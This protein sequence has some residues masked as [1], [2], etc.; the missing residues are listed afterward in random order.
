MIVSDS[1]SEPGGPAAGRSGGIMMGRRVD[2]ITPARTGSLRVAPSSWGRAGPGPGAVNPQPEPDP[3][4][5]SA[6]GQAAAHACHGDG[7]GH[8]LLRPVT[9]AGFRVHYDRYTA[10][11]AYGCKSE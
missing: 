8:S 9:P 1:D 10:R 4:S 2:R 7:H 6:L 5:A 3:A 11:A